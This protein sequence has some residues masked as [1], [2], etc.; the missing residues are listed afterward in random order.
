MEKI[1]LKQYGYI[2]ELRNNPRDFVLGGQASISK[3]LL[4]PDGDWRPFLVDGEH[5][6][7]NDVE[8]NSCVSFASCNA[9]EILTK[10]IFKIE[11]NFSDRYLAIASDTGVNG[12]TPTK[13]LETL[14]KISGC[15]D[16]Q[17]LPFS[18]E[19]KTQEDYLR[20]NPLNKKFYDE[21]RKWLNRYDF[22]HQWVETNNEDLMR[23]LQQSP[24]LVSVVAWIQEGDFYVKPNGYKDNHA[25]L[26]VAYEEGKCWWVF[27]SYPGSDGKYLKKLRWDFFA[28]GT[29]IAKS[30]ALKLAKPNCWQKFLRKV[31]GV[32]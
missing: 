6:L 9:I 1:K 25:T 18:D 14:R 21:G 29:S 17:W 7:K 26:L 22:E 31:F 11:K 13:V 19:I 23:G 32:L 16:E 20:P 12:N 4:Q 10:R 15:I 2:P 28:S 24:L 30:F 27:D 3:T 5:Q 8:T